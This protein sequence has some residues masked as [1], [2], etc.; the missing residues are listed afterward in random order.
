MAEPSPLDYAIRDV[1]EAK[2]FSQIAAVFS[3]F[4]GAYGRISSSTP[5]YIDT[6]ESYIKRLQDSD[7]QNIATLYELGEL[8][9]SIRYDAAFGFVKNSSPENAALL[10][11]AEL[12]TPGQVKDAFVASGEAL[13]GD[14][15]S[16]T[17]KFADKLK[18]LDQEAKGYKAEWASFLDAGARWEIKDEI[19]GKLQD[20]FPELQPVVLD[21]AAVQNFYFVKMKAP[22]QAEEI[23]SRVKALVSDSLRKRGDE[24]SNYADLLDKISSA[25]R[26]KEEHENKIFEDVKKTLV[27]ISSVSE[28]DAQKWADENVYIANNVAQKLKKMNYPKEQFI[29]DIAEVYRYV[30]G[31]MGPVEIIV[32]KGTRR[33]FAR[34]RAIICLDSN[35]TK[36]TLFHECGHLVEAWDDCSLA[37]SIAF[38][39]SRAQGAP[40]SLKTLTGLRY[41][42]GEYAFP[43]SFIDPYV[44]KDYSGTASEVFSMAVQNMASPAHLANFIEKDP[45]HF[46]LFLGVCQRQ[47]PELARKMKDMENKVKETAAKQK[48]VA[49][50]YSRWEKSLKKAVP[51]NLSELLTSPDGVAGYKAYK[52]G[53]KRK[54]ILRTEGGTGLAVES[55]PSITMIAYLH[56]M[57]DRGLLPMDY[58]APNQA[59]STFYSYVCEGKVPGWFDEYYEFQRLT[60]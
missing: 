16:S 40:K 60:L 32:Q 39:K 53:S 29:K 11:K 21:Q 47:S 51:S 20:E 30:G 44:G 59:R 55:L 52:Y 24:K 22:E 57:N 7:A 43:D 5:E 50:L 38:I 27:S 13:A 42:A 58:G 18:L 8:V 28:E 37:A 2:T 17:Q 15:I 31:K 4:D 23:I 56:I 34:G 48:Q 3:Y 35:F 14:I 49:E 45:E 12:V 41:R 46:K 36:S 9:K 10:Q 19:I 25:S 6:L 54:Y 1:E 33:A 26:V